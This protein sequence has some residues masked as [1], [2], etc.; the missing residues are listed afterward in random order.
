VG[1]HLPVLKIK[2]DIN[3]VM[4]VNVFFLSL[5]VK[6]CLKIPLIPGEQPFKC[7][8]AGCQN[9]YRQAAGL[10]S[11]IQVNHANIR[12]ECRVCDAKLTDKISKLNSLESNCKDFEIYIFVF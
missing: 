12:Y 1:R 11:H 3:A 9:A 2:I 10:A 5:G 7:K 4:V 6:K 8:M